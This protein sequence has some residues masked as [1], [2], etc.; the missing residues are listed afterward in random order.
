MTSTMHDGKALAVN[1]LEYVPEGV[2][3]FK[4]SIPLSVLTI[5]PLTLPRPQVDVCRPS[6]YAITRITVP[7]TAVAQGY[8]E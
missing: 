2:A 5:K 1:D 3:S 8:A 7:T 6:L 4:L